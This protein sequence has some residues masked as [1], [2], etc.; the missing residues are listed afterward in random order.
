MATG[1]HIACIYS[2][3]VTS[4]DN[5]NNN[6]IK[7]ES[8]Y[9]SNCSGETLYNNNNISNNNT[10]SAFVDKALPVNSAL[11]NYQES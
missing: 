11:Y 9:V 5:Y 10:H 4:Y 7:T 8:N 6:A 1:K 3:S 2:S